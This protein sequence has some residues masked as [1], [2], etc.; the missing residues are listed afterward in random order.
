MCGRFTLTTNDYDAVARAL[1]AQYNPELL[2][3][4]VARYN[5]APSDPH[6]IV[7][8]ETGSRGRWIEPATWGFPAGDRVLINARS[9]TVHQRPSFAA[10]L[11]SRRCGVI[12]DG[13]LE[14]SGPKGSRQPYWFRR[15]DRKP[16]LF[17]GLYRDDVDPSSGEVQ[18]RFTVLTTTPNAPV[19]VHHDRMP[20]MLDAAAADLWLRWRP[21]QHAVSALSEISSLFAPTDDTWLESIPVSKRVG[22]V[23]NDDPSCLERV[24]PPPPAPRQQSLF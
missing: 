21:S 1:D 14:W 10:S 24:E 20:V 5:I 8:E 11:W 3:S 2:G 6:W 15:P 9:E 4:F 17:A 12:A 18:R 23:A 7:C 19:A 13:F 16:F 22:N